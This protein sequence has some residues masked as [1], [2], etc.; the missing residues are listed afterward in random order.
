M[1]KKSAKKKITPVVVSTKP[2]EAVGAQVSE[3]AKVGGLGN[4]TAPIDYSKKGK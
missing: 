2:L 4:R 1:L 3:S